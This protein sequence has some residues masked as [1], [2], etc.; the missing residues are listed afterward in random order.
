MAQRN[1]FQGNKRKP[2]KGASPARA[3]VEASV[4]PERRPPKV[5]GEAFVLL[6]DGQKNTF[7]YSGGQWQPYE[8]SIAECRKECQVDELPQKVRQ[9][10][11]YE[12][13]RPV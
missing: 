7:H 4:P 10:T 3:P 8:L 13:R 1:R 5:Y 9:M 2:Q 11:R 6:E 12:V